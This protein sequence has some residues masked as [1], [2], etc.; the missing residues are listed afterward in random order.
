MSEDLGCPLKLFY[1]VRIHSDAPITVSE[2]KDPA[3][4]TGVGAIGE[5]QL[6][7]GDVLPQFA[8]EFQIPD[9]DFGSD[10]Y[11]VAWFPFHAPMIGWASTPLVCCQ[12]QDAFR[13]L[14]R[15]AITGQ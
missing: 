1:Q 6:S 4:V 10:W 9:L 7:A 3:I 14:V 2:V 15:P 11:R 5:L 13:C 8:A 12:N